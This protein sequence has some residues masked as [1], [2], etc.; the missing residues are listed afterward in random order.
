VDCGGC[1]SNRGQFGS[2]HRAIV[3]EMSLGLVRRVI[4]L[5]VEAPRADLW[6][7]RVIREWNGNGGLAVLPPKVMRRMPNCNMQMARNAE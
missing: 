4:L 6:T 7:L 1:L 2:S 3:S 5:V